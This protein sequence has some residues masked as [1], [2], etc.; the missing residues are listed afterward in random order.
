MI[1]SSETISSLAESEHSSNVKVWLVCGIAI[2]AYQTEYISQ[3]IA[4]IS[5]LE[6]YEIVK[7][8]IS[9][10]SKFVLWDKISTGPGTFV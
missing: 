4:G 5:I 9:E 10:K 3:I 2:K 8:D 6:V 1:L 7:V